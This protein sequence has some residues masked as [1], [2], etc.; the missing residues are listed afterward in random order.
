MKVHMVFRSFEQRSLY[1]F[2]VFHRRSHPRQGLEPREALAITC[3]HTV[4][5][6]HHRLQ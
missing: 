5:G 4:Q 2:F 1:S 3:Q 6:A